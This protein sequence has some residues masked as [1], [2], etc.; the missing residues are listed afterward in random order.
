MMGSPLNFNQCRIPVI[1]NLP[2][3]VISAHK[4]QLN[5]A[6]IVGHFWLKKIRHNLI[7]KS[8]KIMIQ[9]IGTI[10]LFILALKMA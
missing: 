8:K 3:K 7:M 1:V 4:A 9:T 5:T 10:L 2:W 6:R